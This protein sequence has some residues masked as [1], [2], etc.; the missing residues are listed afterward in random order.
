M[1]TLDWAVL[2]GSLIFIVAY[3]L[4]KSRGASTVRLALRRSPISRLRVD[5]A[6]P[7]A[8]DERRASLTSG[9]FLT[10]LD[11]RLL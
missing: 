11:G 7:T 2:V 5:R 3:G 8:D 6:W 1:R 10:A 4:Y 9:A